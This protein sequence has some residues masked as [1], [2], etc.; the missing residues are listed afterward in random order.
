[1][2]QM[3][4]AAAMAAVLSGPVQA[5]EAAITGTIESQIEA[6]KADD[7]ATAFTYASPAIRMLFGTVERFGMMVRNGYPM[8]WR[9]DTV[10]YL[11]LRDENG[12]QVQRVQIT[13][14]A[15]QVHLLD[16]YMI[17]TGAGWQINGVQLLQSSGVGV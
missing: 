9:P 2:K 11:E 14:G 5:N 6:L 8:V 7:F 13:D 3:I 15:G 1:M 16:Y 10:R 17:E 4:L 12:Q